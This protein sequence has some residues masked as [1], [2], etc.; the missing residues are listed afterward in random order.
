M[1]F[2]V[3]STL[4]YA[5]KQSPTIRH[6]L[7]LC[8][9][10]RQSKGFTRLL[11]G[12][13]GVVAKALSR[14]LWGMGQLSSS[15]ANPITRQGQMGG[16]FCI[17]R[18]GKIFVQP[19]KKQYQL[20]GVPLGAQLCSYLCM[21]LL[22]LT[23]SPFLPPLPPQGCHFL[24]G[25]LRP[26]LLFLAAQVINNTTTVPPLRAVCAQPPLDLGIR[27]LCGLSPFCLLRSANFCLL[28]ST[29]PTPSASG[30]TWASCF[31]L[32]QALMCLVDS[33]KAAQMNLRG[34]RL[35]AGG[36]CRRWEQAH[37]HVS[38]EQLSTTSRKACSGYTPQEVR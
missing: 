28:L 35:Q 1:N 8:I 18:L 26:K 21:C 2:W 27:M 37:L 7:N 12:A 22:L 32:W 36:F 15:W 31:S 38:S 11:A 13:L 14:W 9:G 4:S 25:P 17:L 23:C 16:Y 5:G 10:T 24:H 3:V 34:G 33:L 19:R 29:P 6:I 30:E 20:A